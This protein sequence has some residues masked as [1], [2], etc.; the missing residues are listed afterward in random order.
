[1]KRRFIWGNGTSS[2]R[3]CEMIDG[4]S[5]RFDTILERARMTIAVAYAWVTTTSFYLRWLASP[6]CRASALRQCSVVNLTIMHAARHCV[7]NCTTRT[8]QCVH[9]L[10]SVL[11]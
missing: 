2:G 11:A 9:S 5:V 6:S 3:R 1:M 4:G 7:W 8:M 10:W